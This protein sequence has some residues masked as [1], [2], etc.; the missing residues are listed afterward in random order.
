MAPAH[1]LNSKVE[2]AYRRG[3]VFEKAQILMSDWAEFCAGDKRVVRGTWR[4]GA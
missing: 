4:A 1:T 2:A 3:D